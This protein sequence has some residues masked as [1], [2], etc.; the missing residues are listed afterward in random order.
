MC[1]QMKALTTREANSSSS[2]PT[3]FF[4]ID[5]ACLNNSVSSA[6][7]AAEGRGKDG[8]GGKEWRRG[9]EERM[10]RAGRRGRDGSEEEW[11]E[12][13]EGREGE[14]KKGGRRERQGG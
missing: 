11:K 12:E 8:R 6:S 4:P 5:I 3:G 10:G 1:E 13:G 7:I 9:R 2:H 14:G